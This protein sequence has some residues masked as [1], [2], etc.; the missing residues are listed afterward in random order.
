MRVIKEK[1]E[2]SE[3]EKKYNMHVGKIHDSY[4]EILAIR[5]DGTTFRSQLCKRL[6]ASM[7]DKDRMDEATKPLAT[8][9]DF[10]KQEEKEYIERKEEIDRIISKSEEK[11]SSMEPPKVPN[12]ICGVGLARLDGLRMIYKNQGIYRI[13]KELEQAVASDPVVAKAYEDYVKRGSFQ[14]NVIWD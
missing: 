1:I 14:G 3:S 10:R 13:H 11:K 6:P 9:N 5:T 8:L 4:D 2:W 12:Q 7:E